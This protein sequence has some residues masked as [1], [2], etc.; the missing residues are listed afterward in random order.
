M[1]AK[2]ALSSQIVTVYVSLIFS[3]AAQAATLT[4]GY[5]TGIDPSNRP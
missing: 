4:V 3:F 2:R 5:Q 1:M